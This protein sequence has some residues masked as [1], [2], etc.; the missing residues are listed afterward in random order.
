MCRSLL[1]QY[2]RAQDLVQ[3]KSILMAV[4]RLRRIYPFEAETVVV[5]RAVLETYHLNE[6][7]MG[8]Y[9]GLVSVCI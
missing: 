2:N 3:M 1:P 6:D 5:M 9:Q 7:Q 8:M 4:R